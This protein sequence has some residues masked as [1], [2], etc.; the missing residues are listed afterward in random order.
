MAD[1]DR[2]QQ[3]L[4]ELVVEIPEQLFR[5]LNGGVM[6]LPET[7]IHTQGQGNNL[8]TMGEYCVQI[9]G[10]GRYI[11]IYY[12]SF[13]HVHGSSITDRMLREE[14]RKT[15][16]HELRHHMESLSGV[17]DLEIIDQ[18]RLNEYYKQNIN[19]EN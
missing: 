8:Y 7:K 9:P 2:F 15:L 18:Q 5:E 14:I 3:I 1:I 12:G 17:R 6:L 4:E 13:I 19:N 16:A 11:V 10:L